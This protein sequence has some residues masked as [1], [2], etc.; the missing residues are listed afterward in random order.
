MSFFYGVLFICLAALLFGIEL[1]FFR[2]PKLPKWA[3]GFVFISICVMVIV[4]LGATGLILFS[5]AIEQFAA[6]SWV[7]L[8][9]SFIAVA[10]TAVALKL[11]RISEKLKKIAE[12]KAAVFPLAPL[13]SQAGIANGPEASSGQLAA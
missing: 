9:Y 5:F 4:S 3:D 2:N 11:L 7:H 6:I 8:L 12:Q 13:E 1:L 10:A